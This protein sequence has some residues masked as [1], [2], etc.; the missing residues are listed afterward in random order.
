MALYPLTAGTLT[1]TGTPQDAGFLELRV[2]GQPDA[3]IL[4]L[5][6]VS[7][8]DAVH[9]GRGAA[10][11]LNLRVGGRPVLMSELSGPVEIHRSLDGGTT[12]D[13]ALFGRPLSWPWSE[14]SWTQAPFFLQRF[15]GPD[16]NSLSPLPAIS[17]IVTSG[18][19]A[20]LQAMDVAVGDDQARAASLCVNLPPKPRTRASILREIFEPLG[21]SLSMP[22]DG[23]NFGGGVLLQDADPWSFLAAFIEP[24]G[25]F[26]E[27]Q[28]STIVCRELTAVTRPEDAVTMHRW[29]AS[30]LDFERP[31]IDL[32]AG[33][34]SL[35]VLR[36]RVVRHRTGVTVTT[37]RQ[38]SWDDAF[39]VPHASHQQLS[40]GDQVAISPQV[41]AGRALTEV[42]EVREE[43]GP[44]N[45]L[46]RRT[47]TTWGWHNP[48]RALLRTSPGATVISE[49][50]GYVYLETYL[51]E[52]KGVQWPKARFLKTSVEVETPTWDAEGYRIKRTVDRRGYHLKPR[53]VAPHGQGSPAYA[54]AYV[55]DDGK[56]YSTAHEVDG[57]RQRITDAYTYDRVGGGLVR[58]DQTA[59]GWH[60]R[61]VRPAN[62]SP[63]AGWYEGSDETGYLEVHAS[64]QTIG[65]RVTEH[66]LEHGQIVGTAEDVSSWAEPPIS[67]SGAFQWPHGP[68][69]LA[70]EVW[71]TVGERELRIRHPGGVEVREL[72]DKGERARMVSQ[73]VLTLFQQSEWATAVADPLEVLLEDPTAAARWGHSVQVVDTP[74]AE[75]EDEAHTVLKIRRWRATAPQASFTMRLTTAALGDMAEVYE[76]EWGGW[77]RAVLVAA[78]ETWQPPA[79]G[80]RPD[81][82]SQVTVA[83]LEAAA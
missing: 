6:I 56:S 3:G 1:V 74:W 49:R 29:G 11:R 77:A 37:T 31:R 55:F 28:G 47:V 21:Y 59:E 53:A 26:F 70:F 48:R 72:T 40:N 46:I 20:G 32:P 15:S 82:S 67:A 52:G 66:A 27:L 79:L 42:I 58:I 68:S 78:G 83:L 2:P 71:Q 62:G 36:S 73:E 8:S 65:A 18:Q 63:V 61:R 25:L 22:D 4:E 75:T 9:R 76:P 51:Q 43:T 16:V 10:Y 19:P 38:E 60:L 69:D 81:V 17:G 24:R 80:Q 33:A 34:P 54:D 39:V 41:P 12:A 14:A 64:F 13:F 30:D 7:G 23:G 5:N 45:R 57:L 35:W 44:D 50:P